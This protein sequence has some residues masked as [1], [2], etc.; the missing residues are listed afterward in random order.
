MKDQLR[1]VEQIHARLLGHLVAAAKPGGDGLFEGDAERAQR[2][3]MPL[4]AVEIDD[5]QR[6]AKSRRRTQLPDARGLA[7]II[8]DQTPLTVLFG[9][10]RHQ[11][12]KR[13]SVALI[14]GLCT[15]SKNFARDMG[16][17]LMF[18]LRCR[19]AGDENESEFMICP[20]GSAGSFFG[21][22]VSS[23]RDERI[24]FR[25]RRSA[26]RV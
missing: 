22:P 2:A 12:I 7:E 24:P 13:N 26:A 21:E 14:K 9:A 3:V 17:P 25:S 8:V 20:P 1:R 19:E 16:A 15:N 5:E 10:F 6:S 18:R 4:A 23:G 11:T